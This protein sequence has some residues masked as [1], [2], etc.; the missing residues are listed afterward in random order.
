MLVFYKRMDSDEVA[1]KFISTRLENNPPPSESCFSGYEDF[2]N[3]LELDDHFYFGFF[4]NKKILNLIEEI[5]KE[6]NNIKIK[7]ITN[8]IFQHYRYSDEKSDFYLFRIELSDKYTQ[9]SN[10]VLTLALA[11]FI[12]G[13]G[14][15]YQF[16]EKADNIEDSYITNLLEMFNKCPDGTY[17]KWIGS[18]D[19]SREI[20]NKFDDPDIVNEV[21]TD[22]LF[23]YHRMP[24]TSMFVRSIMGK[25][26]IKD[27]VI[28]DE[29]EDW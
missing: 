22:R 12:R 28:E 29:E 10:Y 26:E 17:G 24:Y 23:H 14:S 6:F 7:Y 13:F 5:N 2:Y 8:K 27:E 18:L 16:A 25:E 11:Q 20:F 15:E 4:C 9:L 3:G 21:S 1:H 19:C